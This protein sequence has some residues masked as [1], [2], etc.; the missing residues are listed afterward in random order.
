MLKRIMM[1]ALLL[2]VPAL[3]HADS[4]VQMCP[5]GERVLISKDVGDERWAMMYDLN[6]YSVMGNVFRGSGEPP[7]FV[8]CERIETDGHPDPRHE[9]MTFSCYGADSCPEE[10]CEV[11]EWHHL[12]DVT[13]PGSFFMA[14]RHGSGMMRPPA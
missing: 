11:G 10:P 5:D 2:M 4:G 1:T 3:V 6:D 7:A 14:P 8:W 13:L 12:D 9:M